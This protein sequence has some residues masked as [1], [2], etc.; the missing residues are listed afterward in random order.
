MDDFT[1]VNTGA[2]ASEEGRTLR[3]RIVF[4]KRADKLVKGEVLHLFFGSQMILGRDDSC[5]VQ[6]Q[7][8]RISRKHTMVQVDGDVV[9]MVD[10]GSTNGTTRN[11][12]P[13]TDEIIL[14]NG[15]KVSLA[16]AINFEVRI[17]ERN[18]QV[19]SVRLAAGANAFL[20]SP[21]EIIMG[22]AQ[23]DNSDCD[24]MIYDPALSTHHIKLEHFYGNTFIAALDSESPVSVNEKIIKELEIKSGSKIEIG[25]TSFRW[26]VLG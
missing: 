20:L 16:Q 22:Q 24:I 13:V 7:D 25:K 23:K 3:F 4:E 19:T 5:D 14:V 11:G 9:R 1:K 10:L 21:S 26:E 2:S 17:I 8:D 15:D 18:E 6:I 12:H